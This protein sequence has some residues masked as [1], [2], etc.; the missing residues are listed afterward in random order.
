LFLHPSESLDVHLEL[1]EDVAILPYTLLPFIV[2]NLLICEQFGCSRSF[3]MYKIKKDDS[4][5]EGC[6]KDFQKIE[7]LYDNNSKY[8]ICSMLLLKNWY[9]LEV[10]V[11]TP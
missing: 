11:K 1:E 7:G 3:N 2:Q 10:E 5:Y 6:K 4:K 8:Y 9:M